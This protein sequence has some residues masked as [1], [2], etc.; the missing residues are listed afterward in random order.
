MFNL[1]NQHMINNFPNY[2]PVKW[3]KTIENQI[4][5]ADRYP[6]VQIEFVPITKKELEVIS[7]IN[8]IRLERLAFVLLCFAKFN[9]LRN[10]NNNNWVNYNI[11][12][13]FKIARIP[14]TIEKQCLF[15]NDIKQLGLIKYSKKIENININVLYIND[16]SDIVLKINDFRELGYEYMLWKGYKYI[17]CGEC[18]ILVKQKNNRIKYC[19]YCAAENRRE[20]KRKSWHKNKEKYKN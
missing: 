16:N 12:D 14:T 19:K 18:G 15:L 3:Y 7:S 1:L 10:K 13:I 20:I 5:N 6:L 11:R 4:K 9:N 2:N 8:N 17:R